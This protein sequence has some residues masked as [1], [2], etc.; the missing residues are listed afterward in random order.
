VT[1]RR[2]CFFFQCKIEENLEDAL[3]VRACMCTTEVQVE[4]V[5]HV[6]SMAPN[7]SGSAFHPVS[8]VI[9]A[10]GSTSGVKAAGA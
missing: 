8:Y 10:A 3:P 2:N 6:I 4:A 9:G 7:R 1:V 5:W